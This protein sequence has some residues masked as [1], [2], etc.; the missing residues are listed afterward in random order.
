MNVAIFTDNDFDKVNG[1][2]TTLRAVLHYA[3]DGIRPCIYTASEFGDDGPGYFAPAS[4]GMPVPF[5]SVMRMYLPRIREYV[6]RV[7]RDRVD[8]VHV[9]TPGPIG[10]AGMYVAW[11]TG[12]AVVGTFHTDLGAYTTQ[13]SG[14]R[15]LGNLV[16]RQMRWTYSRC[17]RVLVPSA[18]ARELLIN[19][20]VD[21]QQID[22]LRRGVD[23]DLFSPAKR[24]PALRE[25]WRVCE[26]R[27]AIVYAGRLSC[28]KG[29][30]ILR[31]VQSALYRRGVEHRLVLVGDG[32]CRRDLQTELPDSVFTGMLRPAD[33]AIAL[34]SADLFLLP[35]DTETASHAVLE[36]QA[37]AL[38]ALVS[39]LGG[40]KEYIRP[41]ETG[42]VCHAG[43]AE[44]FGH[45]AAMVLRDAERHRRMSEAAR[46]HALTFR[47]QSTLAPLYRA[48]TELTAVERRTR[49]SASSVSEP[50]PN[51]AA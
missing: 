28:E 50:S 1:V 29:L 4:I 38:P 33:E 16:G 21:P 32:P 10:V 48:Y 26:R 9:T 5:Y 51:T 39:S 7:G 31:A 19:A 17:D 8:L 6:L 47:W 41:D 44:A 22:L 37:S 42:I 15:L 12:L 40:P 20:H 30:G 24:S 43:S 35:S 34:A 46:I 11:R 23:A 25:R 14:S 3:P 49:R 36:A 27:P 18:S 45:A 13:L 2:T